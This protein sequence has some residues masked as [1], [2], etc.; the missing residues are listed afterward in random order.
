MLFRSTI[1]LN[2][3]L[4]FSSA[5]NPGKTFTGTV[6]VNGVWNE[7][8]YAVTPTFV[9]GLVNNATAWTAST[10]VH[11][12]SGTAQTISGTTE[13]VIPSVTITGT[14][15]N[16]NTLTV[17]TALVCTAT[18][19]N[20]TAGILNIG[21]TS[22]GLLNATTASNTVNYNGTTQTVL[23]PTASYYNLTLST[24]G[25]KTIG[26]GL[27]IVNTLTI[28]GTAKASLTGDSTSNKLIL[29]GVLARKFSWGFTGSGAT[30]INTNFFVT[31]G[32]TNGTITPTI[33]RTVSSSGDINTIEDNT[34]TTSTTVTNDATTTTTT[35]TTPNLIITAVPVTPAT[36]AVEPGC[37]GGNIYN[38]STGAKCINNVGTTA[39]GTYN[40]GTTTLKN[41]SK[42]DAVMELQRFLNKT[43]N[44]KLTLD[45]KLGPKTIAIIKQWQ[46]AN[47]LVADGVVGVK[48]KKLMK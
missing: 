31:N 13:T 21:G 6:T 48:T 23:A 37:S 4:I 26:A 2:G 24:S 28:S 44:I 16:V 11:T 39:H 46:K 19:T 33:G 41:G 22:S 10:G 8:T 43:L 38:T 42:G 9:A 35:T 30:N 14:T 20:G 25:T 12:F 17:A 29:G 1:D 3:S 45:G 18:L 36:P 27:T 15:T 7:A 34:T 47:G 40:F 32:G 5:T